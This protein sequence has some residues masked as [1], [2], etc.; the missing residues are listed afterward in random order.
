LATRTKLHVYE[1]LG[2]RPL[3]NGRSFSTKAG[4]CALPKEVLDAMREAGECCVRMDELQSAASEVIARATGAEAGIVTSGAAAALTLGTAACLA[5][6]DVN[7]MNRLPDTSGMP[8]EF[9]VHRAH[10]NDYDHAVRAAGAEFVEVGF[11]Y[12]TFAYE[13]ESAIATRTAGL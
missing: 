6:F 1:Q 2:V 4:G 8:D 10:R 3:I 7:R 9:I 5:R 11:G 12:Y 13:V